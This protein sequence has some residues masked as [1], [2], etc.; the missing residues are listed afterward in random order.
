MLTTIKN[1]IKKVYHTP[2][3][4]QFIPHYEINEIMGI[5][6]QYGVEFS[7]AAKLTRLLYKIVNH[8]KYN[9]SI[10]TKLEEQKYNTDTQVYEGE[11]YLI[12]ITNYAAMYKNERDHELSDKLRKELS[13]DLTNIQYFRSGL[14]RSLESQ[15]AGNGGGGSPPHMRDLT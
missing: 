11:D 6:N 8:P 14:P 4:Q 7:K 9:T 1:S 10:E 13:G 5:N 15:T 12:S 3:T 2:P